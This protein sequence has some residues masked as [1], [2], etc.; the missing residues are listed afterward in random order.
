M[1]NSRARARKNLPDLFPLH[2]YAKAAWAK[3]SKSDT[4]IP[5]KFYDELRAAYQN[6]YAIVQSNA[7]IEALRRAAKFPTSKAPISAIFHSFRLILGR[8]II[9]W[10][11]LEAWML[12]PERARAEHSR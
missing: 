11:G 5:E 3:A 6:S 10:N 1:R 2:R 12:F 4:E 7:N 8:A 9:S